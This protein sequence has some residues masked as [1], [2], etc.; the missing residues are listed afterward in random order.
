MS[1]PTGPELPPDH[2]APD[3][4]EFAG[5]ASGHGAADRGGQRHYRAPGWFT[6]N[7]FNRAIRTLTAVGVS[8]W[9]S[10]TLAVRGRRSG[11]WR[12]TPVNVLSI[13]GDRFLVAARGETEWVRNIR[14]AQSGELRLGRSVEPF[15]VAE[16]HDA[17]K[18][19]V[20]R[21]YLR[22]WKAEVG[23]FFGGVGPDSPDSE[24]ARI[25]P[26]HPVFRIVTPAPEAPG[27]SGQS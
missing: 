16:L 5:P 12:T 14:V 10:R 21:A 9:G 4:G 6:R 23:M 25:A 13:D 18:P 20:L 1:D 11:E 3:A 26:R 2:H 8:V 24:L 22:R 27:V 15:S 17:D 19:P 7:V